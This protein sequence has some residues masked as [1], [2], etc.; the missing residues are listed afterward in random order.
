MNSDLPLADHQDLRVPD[1]LPVLPL[2]GM[3][4]FPYIILP[5]SI[6]PDR[7]LK[8][9]DHALAND[10]L[11]ML[12]AQTDATL[13]EPSPDQ[14]HRVGTVGTIMR[15]LKLPDGRIRILVQGL[16]RARI[17]TMSQI[18]PFFKARIERLSDRSNRAEDLESKALVRSVRDNLEQA[19]S[20]GQSIS[21]E[22]MV[23]A[24]NL[25][26]PG[27]LADLAASNLDL[28]TEA[29]QAI[30][31]QVDDLDRLKAVSEHL[32]R[33]ID[34]LK[35]QQAISSQAREEIDRSQREFFMRQQLKAIRDE[36]GEGDE[37]AEEIAAHRRSAQEKGFPE[38]ALEELERQI[39]RLERSLPDGAEGTVIRTY[40]DWLTGLPWSQVSAD[41]LDIKNARRVL[42]KDHFGLEKVKQ[43]ILEFLAV[44]KLNE[45]TKGPILCFVGP[46]GVGKTS[47]G[48][49]IARALGRKFVRISLGG[50]RDEAE[51]RGHRRTYVGAMPGRILQG[52]HRAG[53]SNPVFM[54]DEI[55]KVGADYRGDPSSALLE[56]LDPE[57]NFDFRDHYLGV[58]YDLARVIF[59]TTANLLDPVQPAFLDRMEVIRISGYSEE[60]KIQ[61]A[62][63]HLIPKQL[64]ENGITR[65]M[66]RFTPAGVKKI[67]RGYTR[68]AGL[69]ALE[70]EIG[71]VCRK[72]AVLA[73]EGE[74][75]A[76]TLGPARIPDYLG[77]EKHFREALL[78]RHRIGVATGLAW[79]ADGGDLLLI[80]VVAVPGKGEL[81][82]TG[83]LG[84]VMKESGQAALSYVRTFAAAHGYDSDFFAKNDL[85]IHAPAGAV[86][87]DGPSAGITIATALTSTVSG[88]AVDRRLAM[89]GEITL[90]GDILPVG[91]VK[92]KV[93][94]ARSAGIKTLLLPK[95]NE[96]DLHEI[97]EAVRG[98][99]TFHFLSHMDDVLPRALVG[100]QGGK[101]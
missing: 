39:H 51:I 2:Q 59:I 18:E 75:P 44:R 98:N 60:E 28:R 33:E 36:L 53:T 54:L 79:T 71:A 25:D 40:L 20:L 70:R 92:E 94:A 45:N 88:L 73:A 41:D 7:S 69:R 4:V 55:D 11:L 5:L 97:P 61:I 93:L 84:E 74:S 83:R 57:Q 42:D 31:E 78:D 38:E 49:S 63:K 95:L 86:P 29:A 62:R 90:R 77:P 27:R 101:G 76:L 15:M 34:L 35:I 48:R 6:G 58:P 23:V 12:V 8:A 67:I 82:L 37:F 32:H 14:L 21:P 17:E 3:V 65:K 66:L 43:R 13:E 30:L 87:K 91:G 80:E 99:L 22:V 24:A 16:V 89:T 85:H 46:P 50:V 81:M 96:R 64:G 10:R 72:V 100:W 19:L 26:E 47:L 52:I 68:E 56:V 1:V 9:V